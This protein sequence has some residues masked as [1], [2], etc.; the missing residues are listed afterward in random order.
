MAIPEHADPRALKH[1]DKCFV[2]TSHGDNGT[3]YK[4]SWNSLSDAV[5]T[6]CIAFDNGY[7]HICAYCG[8]LPYPIQTHVGSEVTGYSCICKEAMDEVEFKVALAEMRLR[9]QQELLELGKTAPKYNPEAIAKVV[10]S[11]AR[12]IVDNVKRGYPDNG[13]KQLGITVPKKLTDTI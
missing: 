7:S 8:L 6:E 11:Q 13:L 12:S 9:H 3:G 10:M 5:P 4:T 2:G 1:F